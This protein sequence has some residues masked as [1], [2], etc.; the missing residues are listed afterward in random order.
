MK[1]ALFT[2]AMAA[3][4]AHAADEDPYLWLEDVEGARSMQ[5]VREQNAITQPQLESKPGF[6]ALQDRM[7]KVLT[8]RDRIPMVTKRG[9]W[10]YNFWQDAEHPRGILRR[11]TMDE[12]RKPAPAWETVIDVDRISADEKEAWA[13]KGMTCLYPDYRRCLVSLSRGGADAIVVR[14]FDAVDKRFVKDGF[15]LPEAKLEVS[16]RDADSIYVATDFGAGSMT[17]SG[18]PRVVKEWKRGTPLAD[19]RTVYEGQVSD[20]GASPVVVNEPGRRYELVRRSIQFYDGENFYRRGDEWVKLD[21]PRDSN[22]DVADGRLLVTLRTEWKPGARAFKGGSLISVDLDKFLAGGRDFSLVFEPTE[23]VSLQ[24]SVATRNVL[25]LDLLDNVKSRVVEA[26]FVDGAWKLR[27]V[28]VPD[29]SSIG[30]TAVDRNES[31]EYWMTVT[32]YLEPTTLYLGKAGSD[33]REKLKSMPAFFDAKGLSVKQ[34]EATAKDG[35]KIPY[36]VV[37]RTDAKLDGTTPAILYGYGGFEISLTPAYS[38]KIGVGWLEWGGAWIV[39]N[40]RGGGEFGPEWHSTALREGRQ[41]TH[42]DFIA[43]AED[44]EKRGIS[45]PKHLGIFGGSQGGLLV[46]AAFTQAPQDFRA[47]V[48]EVPLA[49][50]KRYNHL[51]AGASWMAEYGNPDAPADWAFIS[52][53]SPYQNLRKDAK[54]P[55]VF[56]TTTTRDDRVHPAHARKMVARMKEQGHDVLYFENTEGGHGSGVTPAQQAYSAALIYTFFRSE[57]R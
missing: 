13:F 39:A 43:V 50:M 40:L 52:K 2:L 3:T 6:K 7:L 48:S 34:Y 42:T 31:D 41:K 22:V 35:T 23:R 54:Y 11:A 16:W 14:E 19:A 37:M 33:A 28:A 8:S 1:A 46:S 32:S 45:S 30:V 15:T 27:T 29:S 55:R 18:Y 38:G 36:F 24:A 25:L 47:V 21:V 20:V 17:T 44:L 4:L 57:L 5:W 10:L 12:Y 9:P 51:L 49:D 53:Y 26:R 56:F